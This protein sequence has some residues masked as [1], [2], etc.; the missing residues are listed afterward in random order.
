MQ[1]STHFS[2]SLDC[3]SKLAH[4]GHR[5]FT[6][7]NKPSKIAPGF[8]NPAVLIKGAPNTRGMPMESMIKRGA[9]NCILKIIYSGG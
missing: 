4:S 9:L 3:M 1:L 8:P 7:S 2:P 5:S 6:F